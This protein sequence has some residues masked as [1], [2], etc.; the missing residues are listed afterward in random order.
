MRQSSSHDERPDLAHVI[1][2][3]APGSDP[4]K[5]ETLED[6]IYG[7]QSLQG[8]LHEAFPHPTSPERPAAAADAP[9][10]GRTSYAGAHGSI[11]GGKIGRPVHPKI[12]AAARRIM[13]SD[14]SRTSSISSST[15]PHRGPVQSTSATPHNLSSASLHLSPRRGSAMSGTPRSSSVRSLGLSDEEGSLF[16]DCASQVIHSSSEDEDLVEGPGPGESGHAHAGP[17]PT[18]STLPQLV[19]PS[20]SMPKRRPFTERG[21]NMGR[22]K[23]LV[24]GSSGVGKTSLIR[25]ILQSC[26]DVVH[27]DFGGANWQSKIGSLHTKDITEINASTRAYPTWWSDIDERRDSKRKQA[28]GGTILD[29]NICFVDTPGWNNSGTQGEENLQVV[30]DDVVAYIEDSL[31]QNASM[32]QLGDSDILRSLSGGGGFQVD[33]ILY[34]F[35]P[36]KFSS[37]TTLRAA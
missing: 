21:R 8:T 3:C 37:P 1:T 27:V 28:M 9:L 15:S 10:A 4:P 12:A 18:T 32:S 24:V 14:H 20:L 30:T 2:T 34:V 26:E 19:M 11:R 23:V 31:R 29:R 6:S 25:N 36:G 16:D 33:L 17:Q 7:V 35:P 13:S 5:A 22:L